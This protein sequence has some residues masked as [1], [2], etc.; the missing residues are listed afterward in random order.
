MPN[1]LAHLGAQTFASRALF[2]QSDLRWIAVGCVVPDVPWI[3]LRAVRATGAGF[4]PYDLRLYAIVQSS[5]LLAAVACA[6]LAALSRTP[7]RVLALLLV[8]VVLHLALDALELKW[9]NGVVVEAPFGW[10]VRSLDLLA[11]ESPVI[12]GLSLLGLAVLIAA[13]RRAPAGEPSWARWP[14]RPALVAALL[15]LYLA[16]PLAFLDAAEAAGAHHID[17]LRPPAPRAGKA[18]ALYGV[19]LREDAS[20]AR[21]VRT[22]AGEALRVEGLAAAAEPGVVSLRGRFVDEQTVRVE[23]LHRHWPRIREAASLLGL[24]GVAWLLLRGGATPGAPGRRSRSS[25]AGD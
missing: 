21:S 17:V 24:G 19:A 20:G 1:T 7:W 4:D 22:F 6:A 15:A 8:N 18:V 16:T 23:A 9:G 25:P 11:P 3:L 10:T 2:R 12:L 14:R 5:L 13:A